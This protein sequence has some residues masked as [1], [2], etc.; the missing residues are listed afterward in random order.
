M[1]KSPELK[2]GLKN[3]DFLKF[4]MAIAVV[5]I[6]SNNTAIIHNKEIYQIVFSGF[7]K[8]C[9]PVFFIITS[10]FVFRGENNAL[11]LKKS[12]TKFVKL[13]CVWS[14]IYFPFAAMLYYVNSF[15]IKESVL[16]Y[17]KGFFILGEHYYSWPLWYL[18][19]GIYAMLIVYGLKKLKINDW[20]IFSLSLIVYSLNGIL[21]ILNVEIS[22][23]LK[24]T[25]LNGRVITAFFYISVG[26]VV[27][28]ILQEKFISKYRKLL[29]FLF[30]VSLI[31]MVF[32][33]NFIT[34]MLVSVGCF[35]ASVVSNNLPIKNPI[36]FRK[37]S[38][39]IYFT[40]MI[41]YFIWNKILQFENKAVL[42]FAFVVICTI[43][44]SFIY[45]L[46]L[47]KDIKFINKLDKILF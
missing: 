38:T 16:D 15:N 17:L 33:Q 10:Y 39:I 14:L 8:C 7:T 21:T 12:L 34:I 45:Q 43:V 29:Y 32:Y 9:V 36:F 11:R 4:L 42:G 6:H 22:E 31:M 20:I 41:F 46:I 28:N 27:K 1:E 26:M 47:K 5:F 13:Y 25:V 30:L 37:A 35:L 3:L 40:H 18:M 24:C 23:I 19:A 2:L 44:F